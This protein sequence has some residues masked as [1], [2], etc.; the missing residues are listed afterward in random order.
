MW[1]IVG[2]SKRKEEVLELI[3]DVY[4]QNCSVAD[5]KLW[6]IFCKNKQN[7]TPK[8]SSYNVPDALCTCTQRLDESQDQAGIQPYETPAYLF[9]PG[10][11]GG[12][13][14]I[15]PYPRRCRQ[16]GGGAVDDRAYDAL[17]LFRH[18]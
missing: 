16:P 9:Q 18:V 13:A 17:F 5:N 12:A 14:G 11:A 6:Q 8:N 15:F 4:S 2:E 3:S 10:R 7:P 1:G